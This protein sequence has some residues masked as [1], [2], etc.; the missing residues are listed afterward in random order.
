MFFTLL[1]HVC[2]L[3]LI[4][5]LPAA[6]DL[7]QVVFGG[8]LAGRLLALLLLLP[9]SF[10]VVCRQDGAGLFARGPE[11]DAEALLALLHVAVEP[12]VPPLLL[13]GV[14]V[15]L[16]EQVPGIVVQLHVQVVEFLDALDLRRRRVFFFFNETKQ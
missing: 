1:M 14:L 16:L 5:L 12:L 9:F 2:V 15:A 11:G 4:L 7:V 13:P 3:A 6:E 10:F 8:G